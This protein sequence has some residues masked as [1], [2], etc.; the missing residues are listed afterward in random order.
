MKEKKT[1]FQSTSQKSKNKRYL[2]LLI[3]N[4]FLFL[5]IY[6]VPLAYAEL[7]DKTFFAFLVMVLYLA[8][9]LGFVLAYLIYNRFLCRK[10]I[11]SEQLPA[12]WSVEQKIS[13][14]EDGNRRLQRSKW[15]ITIIFPLVFTLMIDAIDL[16]L[17]DPF[18]RR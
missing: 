13:F 17:I 9:L 12:E 4:T 16:F 3:V 14:I 15:M 1:E 11:T 8:L 6:R 2:I 18:F 7:T 10:G 5:L